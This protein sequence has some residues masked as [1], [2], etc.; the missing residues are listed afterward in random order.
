ME[1]EEDH[2]LH[3]ISSEEDLILNHKRNRTNYNS[4]YTY[5]D[6]DS[7]DYLS[8]TY[9]YLDELDSDSDLGV[10]PQVFEI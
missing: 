3:S 4:M 6:Y 8:E 2:D 7:S 5:V 1:E 10:T 9:S